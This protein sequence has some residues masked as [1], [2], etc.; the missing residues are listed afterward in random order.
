MDAAGTVDALC[1]EAERD[2][3]VRA[4]LYF[5][6]GAAVASGH[7]IVSSSDGTASPPAAGPPAAGTVYVGV[8]PFSQP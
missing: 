8:G 3:V 5:R 1:I 4:S 7:L 6:I 2:V